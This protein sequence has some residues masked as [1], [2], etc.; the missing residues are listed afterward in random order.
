M[1]LLKDVI[2]LN[3]FAVVQNDLVGVEQI[4]ASGKQYT[5]GSE[6][7]GADVIDQSNDV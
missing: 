4:F 7:K 2:G 1:F 3:F 5:S 6:A